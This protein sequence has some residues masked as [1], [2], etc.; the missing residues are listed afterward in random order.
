VKRLLI[1][2]VLYSLAL[3]VSFAWPYLDYRGGHWH[4]YSR[5]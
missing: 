5:S 2:A 1:L 4:L 3:E